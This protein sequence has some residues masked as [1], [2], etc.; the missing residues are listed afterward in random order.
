MLQA[1]SFCFRIYL[2]NTNNCP[3]AADFG[4]VSPAP[5]C[6]HPAPA[7]TA[8][9]LSSRLVEL[10]AS[11]LTCSSED[12]R[13]LASCLLSFIVS[14]PP[15]SR[16]LQS[17]RQGSPADSRAYLRAI[18]T[19]P[20]CSAA[21]RE[22]LLHLHRAQATR[23]IH[24]CSHAPRPRPK[25]STTSPQPARASQTAALDAGTLCDAGRRH[26]ARMPGSGM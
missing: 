2:R 9:E 8:V 20:S 16:V 7:C 10:V 22:H 6:R 17:G 19:S 13:R 23:D 24:P 1:L 25:I 4:T 11:T 15:P 14:T 21:V 12:L 3:A 18:T 26:W 5:P